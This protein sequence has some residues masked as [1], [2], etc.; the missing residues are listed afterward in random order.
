MPVLIGVK[1]TSGSLDTRTVRSVSATRRAFREGLPSVTAAGPHAA[2]NLYRDDEGVWR[3][4][5]CQFQSDVEV[6]EFSS[7]E[8]ALRW[9][10]ATLPKLGDFDTPATLSAPAWAP[11]EAES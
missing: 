4:I 10:R 3:G 11:S 5:V 8:A 6:A 7:R 9:W 1:G 2:A